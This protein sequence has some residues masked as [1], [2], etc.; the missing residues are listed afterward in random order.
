MTEQPFTKNPK[1]DR[2]I[3]NMEHSIDN[4]KETLLEHTG[5]HSQI[6]EQTTTTNGKVASIQKWR[7]RTN[8][9]MISL[10]FL[11]PF[12]I[13]GLWW[14]SSIILHNSI[15]DAVKSA[16]SIYEIPQ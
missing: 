16:L 10:L 1:L 5:V 13:A 2:F 3:T 6:L 8:G 9:V 4:I 11:F 14:A 15:E 12:L 7:E